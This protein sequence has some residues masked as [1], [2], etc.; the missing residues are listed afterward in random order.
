MIVS[1]LIVAIIIGVAVVGALGY[2]GWKFV[3]YMANKD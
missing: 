3:N 2:G 1:W